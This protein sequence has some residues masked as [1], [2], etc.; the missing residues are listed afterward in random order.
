MYIPFHLQGGYEAAGEVG[1]NRR[2]GRVQ[3]TL[4]D[5]LQGER[6]TEAYWIRE[7]KGA[8][9]CK[10]LLTPEALSQ[11]LVS[12]WAVNGGGWDTREGQILLDPGLQSTIVPRS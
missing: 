3:G 9:S 11:E 5:T 2:E 12:H 1:R 7:S 4:G 10:D 6:V 8:L